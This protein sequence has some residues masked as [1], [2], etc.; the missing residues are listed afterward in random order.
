MSMATL[1]EAVA[2]LGLA[3]EKF[4][5]EIGAILLLAWQVLIGIIRWPLRI[6]LVFI[7][8][9][10]IGVQSLFIVALT[11][12]FTGMVF[13][14]Q[15][16]RAFRLFN[17]EALTGAASGLSLA[18]ELAPVLSAIMVTAR[19]GS[20]MAAE[21]G[22][23]R[24]TQQ[25]DALSAMAVNPVSYLVIPRVLA[26][27]LVMPLLTAIFDFVGGIGTYIVGVKFL[28]IDEAVF[29]QKMAWYVDAD[30]LLQGLFK[31]CCFGFI[32]SVVGCY[33]GL[34]AAG[35]AKGVGEATTS[36]VVIASIAILVSDYFI[37]ALFF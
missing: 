4:L 35:G 9:R 8:M 32:L 16:G 37:T 27:V 29:M 13:A 33:K 23:M 30:D 31:A 26:T 7:Q 3:I 19:A 14:L 25:V 5:N 21:I 36:A 28:K 15:S 24:V 2:R 6:P 20:A 10:F 18:R 22:T 17:A 34:N 11:G 1:T 12:M